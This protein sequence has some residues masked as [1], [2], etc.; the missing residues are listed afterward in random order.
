MR[1]LFG[2]GSLRRRWGRGHAPV[3]FGRTRRASETAA[4]ELSKPETR[5]EGVH[6]VRHEAWIG[7]SD[8]CMDQG[9]SWP[10]R[11]GERMLCDK[12]EMSEWP[13]CNGVTRAPPG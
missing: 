5:V 9:F 12:F 13:L 7:T 11:E 10:K 1:A 8:A 3:V 4:R 2:E 6:R